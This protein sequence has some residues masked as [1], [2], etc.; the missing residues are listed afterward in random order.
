[1]GTSLNCAK[2][3]TAKATMDHGAMQARGKEAALMMAFIIKL[4]E[5]VRPF[6]GAAIRSP[7][8]K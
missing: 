1:M 8:F 6:Q 4:E 7:D 3:I 2:T 5:E